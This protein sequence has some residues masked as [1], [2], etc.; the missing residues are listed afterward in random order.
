MLG[1]A[2]DYNCCKQDI[3]I[4]SKQKPHNKIKPETNVLIEIKQQRVK[5]RASIL[6]TEYQL[7]N[8]VTS[9]LFVSKCCVSGNLTETPKF[10]SRKP[11]VSA[12]A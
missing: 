5:S 7:T 1:F 9:H 8:H 3:T 4:F 2:S 6:N 10:Q 12:H 11:S